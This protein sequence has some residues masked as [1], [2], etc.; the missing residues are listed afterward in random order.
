MT[1]EAE[2]LPGTRLRQGYGAASTRGTL[3]GQAPQ[4]VRTRE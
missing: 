2:L 3:T 1:D 4:K